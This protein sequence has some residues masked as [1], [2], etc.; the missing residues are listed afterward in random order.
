MQVLPGVSLCEVLANP[1]ELCRMPFFFMLNRAHGFDA[2]RIEVVV[3]LLVVCCAKNSIYGMLHLTGTSNQGNPVNKYITYECDAVRQ[4]GKIEKDY[5]NC[6]YFQ[7]GNVPRGKAP[8]VS[9]YFSIMIK[10]RNDCIG[11]EN[12]RVLVSLMELEAVV[13]K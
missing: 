8:V 3:G 12:T 5:V 1:F 2:K 6:W 10:S 13:S 9:N 4:C 7:V 11:M